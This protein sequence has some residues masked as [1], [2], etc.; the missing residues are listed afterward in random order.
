MVNSEKIFQKIRMLMRESY[1][2]KK[3]ILINAIRT[4]KEYPYA[5]IYYCLTQ[6]IEDNNEF[7]MDKYGRNGKLINIGEY[8][9][10]QPIELKYKNI[11]LFDRSVPIDYKHSNINFKINQKIV[12]PVIDK[13]NNLIQQHDA[14]KYQESIKI[15]NEMKQN[16]DLTKEFMNNEKVIRGD[17]NWYKHCG[18]VM[19]IMENMFS[20]SIDDLMDFLV[21]HI[22]ESMFYEN[23]L[24]IMNYLYSL[25]NIEENS[26]EWLVKSYFD[27]ICIKT[28]DHYYA[29]LYDFNKLKILKLDNNKWI[30]VDPEERN[31]FTNL[32]ET[33]QYLEL[34]KN[35][36]NEL[37]GFLGYDKQNKHIVFKTKNILSTRDTGARCDEAGKKNTIQ[38]LNDILGSEIF[39]NENT[40]Q[41]KEKNKIIKES[42]GQ[43]ELCIL[44]EFILRYYNK[45]KHNNKKWFLTPEMALYHK[46]YKVINFAEQK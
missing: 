5:Q 17:D 44:Q 1:F 42:V 21:S 39:T 14:D 25:D 4:P 38:N 33:Q 3:D 28:N 30:E 34:K 15:I 24:E 16:Y 6:L 7:I 31:D 18:I 32:I 29:I 13:R 27:N 36:Y 35:D 37:I 40:K 46:L 9:L 10:F 11:S 23:K 20:I 43:I 22:V 26:F 45:I 8:Y 2:Y 19:K 41:I 12:N